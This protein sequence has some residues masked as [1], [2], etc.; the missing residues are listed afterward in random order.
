MANTTTATAKERPYKPSWI[1]RFN[2]WVETLPVREWIFHVVFGIVLIGVQLLF[3]W[4]EGGRG[5][6]ELLPVIIFNGLATPY[7]LALINLLD[8]QAVASLDSMSSVLDTTE[9]EF[10]DYQYRLSHMP[11]LA[12][13][14]AGLAM[15]TL[16]I[17]T[18][19]ISIEPTRYAALEQ[20]SVF[21]VVF[22]IID[23]SSAFLTGVL[24]Y[25]TVRQLRLVNTV[26][27]N[28]IRINLFHLRP[29]RAFSRLTASTAVGLLIFVYVWMLINPELLTDPVIFGYLVLFTLLAI[30]VFVWPLYGVHRLMEKEKERALN[31]IEL[32]LEAIFA[33]FNQGFQEDNYSAIGPLNGTIASLEIQYQRVSDIPTWPWKSETA[34]LALTAIALPLVLMILQF[35]VLQALNP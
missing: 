14:I 32:R 25:H 31:D 24:V 20:L 10:D 33:K 12:P 29:V 9:Q 19:M 7:L 34:R 1:D 3:L 4:L 11:F 6:E 5:P 35:F 28:H 17:L 8:N 16:T 27:S 23:K 22:H 30:L 26:N 15:T 13:L 21:T 18:P 2:D